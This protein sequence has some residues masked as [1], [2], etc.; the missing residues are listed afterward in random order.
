MDYDIAVVGAGP[1]ALAFARALA[2]TSLRILL[3]ER[4]SEQQLAEPA[5]DG[6]DIA[7]THLSREI[8]QRMG[9]WERIPAQEISPLQRARVINGESPYTL[10]FDDGG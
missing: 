8:L 6:R 1:A 10:D 4:Q 9:A 3:I 7:L 5:V 2:D